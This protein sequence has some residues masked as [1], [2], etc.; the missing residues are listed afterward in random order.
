MQQRKQADILCQRAFQRDFLCVDRG[1]HLNDLLRLVLRH[2]A[3]AERELRL[4]I[5]RVVQHC[6]LPVAQGDQITAALRD[7]RRRVSKEHKR[8]AQ[9]LRLRYKFRDRV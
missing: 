5:L 2:G 7:P 4:L 9:L 1:K 3:I 8:D 6:V